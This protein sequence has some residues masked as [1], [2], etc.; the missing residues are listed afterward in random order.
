MPSLSIRS[1]FALSLL[2]L[3]SLIPLA[4][5]AEGYIGSDLGT[6][7]YR[8]T[9]AGFAQMKKTL[10]EKRVPGSAKRMNNAIKSQ[11]DKVKNTD[12]LDTGREFTTGELSQIA[13]GDVS[14]LYAHI[15]LLN[16]NGSV[17][18]DLLACIQK[19]VGSDFVRMEYEA[20]KE[21]RTITKLGSIGLYTKLAYM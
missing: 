11:C 18:A 14:P 3:V 17:S 4:V 6:D 9:D 7:I 5:S 10:V 16:A 21:Q 13:Q 15:K 20:S 12:V 19:V 1:P 8:K 2:I